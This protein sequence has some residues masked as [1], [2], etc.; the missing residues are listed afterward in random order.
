MVI[1]RTSGFL[2]APSSI[3]WDMEAAHEKVKANYYN[4]DDF[5]V[6]DDDNDLCFKCRHF[7]HDDDAYCDDDDNFSSYLFEQE[8]NMILG[9]KLACWA[10]T[11]NIS[12]IALTSLLSISRPESRT[13][14]KDGRTIL[15]CKKNGNDVKNIAG[16]NYHHIGIKSAIINVLNKIYSSIFGRS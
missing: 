2:E 4:D 12:I 7:N 10:S 16:G 15:K 5:V 8:K 11:Y 9:E 14:P 13:L 1:R 3:K 6:A